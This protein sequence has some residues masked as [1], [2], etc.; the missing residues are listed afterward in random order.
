MNTFVKLEGSLNV[1]LGYTNRISILFPVVSSSSKKQACLKDNPTEIR[2][3]DKT[4]DDVCEQ[5]FF[6][7]ISLYYLQSV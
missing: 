6:Y 2:V 1:G 7:N 3:N 5:D 4:F